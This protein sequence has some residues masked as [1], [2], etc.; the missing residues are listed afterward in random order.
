MFDTDIFIT[1]LP[2][3]ISIL[4][5]NLWQYMKVLPILNSWRNRHHSTIL[6][7]ERVLLILLY[8]P[9]LPLSGMSWRTGI[10]CF[11]VSH[12]VRS[13]MILWFNLVLFVRFHF[14]LAGGNVFLF[15][16]VAVHV[17]HAVVGVGEFVLLRRALWAWI[18]VL[19][20]VFTWSLPAISEINEC[21]KALLLQSMIYL[22]GFAHVAD[23]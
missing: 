4:S 18:F 17:A 10:I 7:A 23:P 16:T 12:F 15:G 19:V 5:F 3:H 6:V 13:F 2:G 1:I 22:R 21:G 8:A 9:I 14:R 11:T 20:V